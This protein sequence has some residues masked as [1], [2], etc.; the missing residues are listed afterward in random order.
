MKSKMTIQYRE[1]LK[2]LEFE[3]IDKK[4]NELV[5]ELVEGFLN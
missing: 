4:N 3:E 1:K 5:F 2:D